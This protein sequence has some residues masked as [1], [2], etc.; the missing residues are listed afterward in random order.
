MDSLLLVLLVLTL[1]CK[2]PIFCSEYKNS[3]S[4]GERLVDFLEC[5]KNR[6]GVPGA[7][8]LTMSYPLFDVWENDGDSKIRS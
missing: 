2:T 3:V 1:S 4:P 8:T 5:V 6:S 7:V